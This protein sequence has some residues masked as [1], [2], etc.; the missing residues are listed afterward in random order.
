M[1][2]PLAK[3]GF[4]TLVSKD[5]RLWVFRPGSKELTE[6]FKAGELAKC[7][8]LPAAGPLGMTVKSPDRETALA[9][10]AAKPG[11]VTVVRNEFVWIL[12]PG[13]KDL[14]EFRSAGELAKCVTRPGVGPCGTTVR[15]A[16]SAT[17]DTYL[18]TH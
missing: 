15:S 8:T 9:Y 4:V 16:D 3:P 1:S 6:Y 2:V 18:A 12:T 14:A 10:L 5:G 11:F 13:S 7:V 17:I